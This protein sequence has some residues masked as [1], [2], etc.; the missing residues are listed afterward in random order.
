VCRSCPHRV[1]SMSCDRCTSLVWAVSH[2]ILP[3]CVAL[4]PIGSFATTDAG[5]GSFV[6]EVGEASPVGPDR[7]EPPVAQ[8][9]VAAGEPSASFRRKR[10]RL[11]ADTHVR[12]GRLERAESVVVCLPGAGA[13]DDRGRVYWGESL[14]S[15]VVIKSLPDVVR[16][17]GRRREDASE[18]R[19]IVRR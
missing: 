4:L 8:A 14:R 1:H 17:V 15:S 12:A 18:L 7:G 16:L 6:E 13:G 10:P 5:D 9:S 11:A 19:E 2:I 3:S